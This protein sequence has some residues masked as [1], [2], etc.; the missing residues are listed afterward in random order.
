MTEMQFDIPSFTGGSSDLAGKGRD[1]G[2]KAATAAASTL[3]PPGASSPVGAQISL[4]TGQL[5][6]GLSPAG[7]QLTTRATALGGKTESAMSAIQSQDGANGS[8]IRSATNPGAAIASAAAAGQ[9][10]QGDAA[11]G[12]AAAGD[13]AAMGDAAA[14]AAG[15]AADAAGIGADILDPESIDQEARE[16]AEQMLNGDQITSQ[17]GQMVGQAAQAG[18]QAGQQLSQQLNQA[19]QQ[20][21]QVFQQASQQIGQLVGKAGQSL[22]TPSLDLAGLDAAAGVGGL[23]A[24]LGGAGGGG[25]PDFGGGAGDFGGGMGDFGGGGGMGDFGAL[26]ETGTGPTP[27]MTTSAA[28]M[29]S[30][31]T[32]PA[33]NTSASSNS[34]AA[35]RAP[36]MPMMPMM[37]MAGMGNQGGQADKTTTRDPVIFAEGPLY[38]PPTGVEQNF[39]A[40]PA[41]ETEEPPFGTSA[42][43]DASA[44]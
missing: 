21:G 25:V 6:G 27:A 28:L 3:T 18:A 12:A 5:Q 41:I 8:L 26:N 1:A 32:P 42:D 10:A 23:D 40:P 33:S 2:S 38:E 34:T 39:G 9:G 36:M 19:G 11:G 29:P 30:P 22:S 15:G 20:M 13:A 16:K 37:P 24:G 43:A 35:A 17:M 14:D 44:H 7:P 4:L 31:L